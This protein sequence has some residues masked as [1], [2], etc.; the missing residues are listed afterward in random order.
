MQS[1]ALGPSSGHQRIWLG[2]FFLA[3]G[4]SGHVFGGWIEGLLGLLRLPGRES[5][6]IGPVQQIWRDQGFRG[7]VVPPSALQKKIQKR[8]WAQTYFSTLCPLLSSLCVRK[9]KLRISP[10]DKKNFEH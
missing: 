7:H 8:C 4:V 10:G 2:A 3:K 6:S 5:E 1:S 9:K